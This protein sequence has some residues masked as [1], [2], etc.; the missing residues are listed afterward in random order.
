MLKRGEM[1]DGF[2]TKKMVVWTLSRNIIWAI[3]KNEM[4][5]ITWNIID[6]YSSKILGRINRFR[7]LVQPLSLEAEVSMQAK[8]RVM[9]EVAP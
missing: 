1:V 7:S 3:P 4:F 5:Y 9:A 6:L 8:L 2:F